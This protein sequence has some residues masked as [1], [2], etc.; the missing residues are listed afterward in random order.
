MVS[1][2]C[3]AN[4]SKSRKFDADTEMEMSAWAEVQCL[5][6]KPACAALTHRIFDRLSQCLPTL[7]QLSRFSSVGGFG[8]GV[9]GGRV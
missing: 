9:G 2:E 3:P 8:G 6:V 7:A 5:E 4:R 1:Q